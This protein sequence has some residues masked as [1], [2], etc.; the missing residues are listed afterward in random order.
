MTPRR[1]IYPVPYAWS[2]RPGAIISNTSTSGR[3]LEVW[4]AAGDGHSGTALW[5]KNTNTGSGIALWAIA[6]GTDATLISSADGSGQIFKGFGGDGGEDEFRINN[7]GSIES[8]ADSYVFVPGTEA[9]L[10]ATS[11]GV[12][13]EYHTMGQVVI[14]PSTTGIK[15]VQIGAVLPAV[16]YGQPVKVE[17]VTIFYSTSNSMSYIDRTRV[18]RQKS[19]G[20][21]GYLLVDDGTDRNSTTYTS[22]TVTPT[23]DNLL[24]A[25]EG[26]V[27]ILLELNFN[28]TVHNIT[29]GGVRLRL[30][31]HSLY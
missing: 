23:A 18:Y 3:G 22:Y 11:S 28:S 8:K 19:D 4:S 16:L 10:N 2:L 9:T 6:N 26:F 1:P 13:L 25:A 21:V 27:S 24:S 29:I 31:H 7:N 30:G 14:N 15:Y 17:E 12:A 5:V 20:G